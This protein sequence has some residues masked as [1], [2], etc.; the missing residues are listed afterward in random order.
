MTEHAPASPHRLLTIE[1]AVD[2]YT[3][4]TGQ[5]VSYWQMQRWA[6]PPRRRR[7][8]LP[9]AA[10]PLTG[11]LVITEAALIEAATAPCQRALTEW[12]KGRK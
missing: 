2:V 4:R 10:C 3:A 1:E 11:K 9:F 12:R 8:K 6:S 7:R 5:S